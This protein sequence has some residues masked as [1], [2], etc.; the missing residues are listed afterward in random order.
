MEQN[1]YPF[2][3]V[4]LNFSFSALE[5][6]IDTKTMQVHYE[7][8]Y[9]TYVEKLNTYLQ[10]KPALQN[11]SLEDLIKNFP[12]DTEIQH[13]G[14]GTYNHALYFSTLR[15]APKSQIIVGL[16]GRLLQSIVRDF[17]SFNT[18]KDQFSAAAN[19]VFGSGYAWLVQNA[20]KKLSIIT[21]AN[22]DT[23]LTQNLIPL[24]CIDVW[25]HAYYLKYLNERNNYVNNFYNVIDWVKV[26][27]RLQ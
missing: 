4:P 26:G 18:F 20:N 3:K 7:R 11:L 23:P 21:T 5:P 16:G 14:G 2:Q 13:N 15:P 12:N 8:H 24:L 1:H 19:S 9:N 17:G 10:D 6:Y 22:Q 25:E 27:E